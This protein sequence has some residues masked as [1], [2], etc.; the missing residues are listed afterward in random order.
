MTAI[1]DYLPFEAGPHRMAMGLLALDPT[2]WIELDDA[3]EAEL[4]L[5]RRLL[6]ERAG[7]V[8]AARPEAAAG[9]AETL[10]LLADHLAAR[11][12]TRFT[13]ADGAIANIATG[14]RWTLGDDPVHPLDRAGRLV[15]E[16]L[17]LMQATADGEF[18]LAAASLCFPSRWRLADKL[19]RPLAAIHGPVPG[20]QE[21]LARP[22]DRFFGLIKADKPVWRVNWSIHDDPA[23]FQPSG[24]WRVDPLTLAPDE[25]GERLYLRVERQTLR[26]LPA[27]GDVLFTI[28]T[29]VRPLAQAI[30]DAAT[31]ARLAAA[32]RGLPEPLRAYKSVARFEAPL[33]AWLERLS[34]GDRPL[35]PTLS[36]MNGGEG[37]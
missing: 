31:A 29:Y 32:V 6:A 28:K 35:T 22:V 13:L 11:F 20:Y 17:C 16:D 3:F 14:E 8:F 25:V 1:P 24:H 30:R 37:D 34:D 33:M 15:Q 7:E 10:A 12:P 23:L 27:S 5:K 18:V 19:G 21:K 36:P 4:A 9:S 2:D 26:R